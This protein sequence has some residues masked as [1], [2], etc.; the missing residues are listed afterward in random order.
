M[1]TALVVF[2]RAPVAG[3]AK[4]RLIPALGAAGAALLAE[5]LLAHAVAAAVH[6]RLGPV[7]LCV[8]PDA[9][10]P[11]FGRLAREH[12]VS[13][14]QQGEGDL[15]ERMALALAR[16][17]SAHRAAVLIGSDAPGLDAAA[18]CA[19]AAAL[20]SHD[21]VFVPAL[22]GGYALVGLTRPAPELFTGMAWSTSRVMADTRERARAAGLRCAELPP[23][24]DIDEP[25]D[26]AHLPPGWL[27]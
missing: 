6:A 3:A 11:S 27:R 14:Q 15:G 7:E 12:G 19:A 17:L 26:L 1:S 22:D 10:H 23:V 24:A 2:A 13:L 20:A 25:D 9:T 8:T 21:A 4:T 18:L 5:R 16:A